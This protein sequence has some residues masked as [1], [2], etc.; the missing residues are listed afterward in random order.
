MSKFLF[1]DIP[2]SSE[3]HVTSSIEGMETV[4]SRSV[5]GNFGLRTYGER[6]STIKQA[7]GDLTD[8]FVFSIIRDPWQRAY[9]RYKSTENINNQ[10]ASPSL[11]DTIRKEKPL[12][13][14]ISSRKFLFFP[15][16]SD[17]NDIN[18]LMRFEQLEDDFARVASVLGVREELKTKPEY[19]KDESWKQ[20]F[21]TKAVKAVQRKHHFEIRVGGYVF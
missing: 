8:R 7:Q 9:A 10:A 6:F 3:G 11:L 2:F 16:L 13:Y 12:E 4:S 20:H 19:P 5:F 17:T 14:Y 1:L 21:C 15:R 18:Y